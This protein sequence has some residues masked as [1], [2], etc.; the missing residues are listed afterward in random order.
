MKFYGQ[1]NPPVDQFIYTRYGW[2]LNGGPGFFLESGAFDGVTESNCKFLEESLGWQGIN[3]EPFPHH[4]EKLVVNRPESLNFN[5]AL[6]STNGVRPFT[7]VI[8][9]KLGDDFGNGSLSHTS[10]HR[11]QL[12]E[13]GC[14]FR[15]L[16]VP[17][18]TYD[19]LLE[20]SGLPRVD[21][22]SLD[23]EGH[24]LEV[25][26]GIVKEQFRPR[27]ICIETGHDASGLLHDKLRSMGYE[28]D[29]EY[30]VNSF[31]L[32]AA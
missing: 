19:A 8:H 4:F 14:E 11:D 17:T 9:P 10:E 24:E 23:V 2:I 25:L 15:V 7:H 22:F 28:K 5:C 31:Y 13:K 18:V 6:S 20:S 1:F 27:L 3:V 21:L 30:Q 32:K 29:C 12:R 16:E 26:K